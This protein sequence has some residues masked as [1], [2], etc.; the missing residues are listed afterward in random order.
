M[1]PEE[2]KKEEKKKPEMKDAQT[3]TDRSDYQMIKKKSL[4]KKTERNE[5]ILKQF[6]SLSLIIV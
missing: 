1:K 2:E 6:K 4:G 5:R 3:Q